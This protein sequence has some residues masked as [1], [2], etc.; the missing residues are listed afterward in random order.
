[1]KSTVTPDYTLRNN[2]AAKLS[3]LRP[4]LE[5]KGIRH[6][7]LFGSVARGDD[8]PGSDIDIILDLD[9]E[10]HIDIFDFVDLREF[11]A[12]KLGRNVDVGTRRSLFPGRHDQIIA[13]LFE[14]F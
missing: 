3:E 13:E 8:G 9:P 11:L 2:V 5:A 7:Y 1:M 6:S 12:E 14:I 4:A 10:R